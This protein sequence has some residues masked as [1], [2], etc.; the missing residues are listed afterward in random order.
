MKQKVIAGIFLLTVIA[1]VATNTIIIDKQIEEL[2]IGVCEL[3]VESEGATEEAS[4]LFDNFEKIEVYI[5]LTVNHDDLTNI[6]DC[7]AELV[8]YLSVGEAKEARVTKDRLT[9][10]L[11]HL[12]RL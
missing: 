9:H 7:F 2:S 1:F 11:E 12:R 5:S 10:S 4:R 6:E 8:G 3:D